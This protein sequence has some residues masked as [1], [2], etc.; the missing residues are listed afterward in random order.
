MDPFDSDLDFLMGSPPDY[1]TLFS[2]VVFLCTTARACHCVPGYVFAWMRVCSHTHAR[3]LE[4]FSSKDILPGVHASVTA[5]IPQNAS[6]N[7][8]CHVPRGDDKPKKRA[9]ELLP[10]YRFGISIEATRPPSSS[11]ITLRTTQMITSMCACFFLFVGK[12]G[13]A[14]SRSLCCAGMI[15]WKDM[16]LVPVLGILM[17]HIRVAWFRGSAP[18][19]I[20]TCSPRGSGLHPAFIPFSLTL[21]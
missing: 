19:Q 7:C 5:W 12:R 17:E 15:Q 18:E 8:R 10:N 9:N 11:S 6:H 13:L 2:F 14:L 4:C 1:H 16:G 3:T 21:H 20:R